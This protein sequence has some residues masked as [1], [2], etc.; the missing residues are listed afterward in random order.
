MSTHPDSA[1]P[2]VFLSYVREDSETVDRIQE[3]L[4]AAGVRVWRDTEDL[5]PGQDWRL[6]I[7]QAIQQNALVFI[8]C[9]SEDSARRTA[10]Y[11]NEELYLAVEQLRLRR[12]D[13]DWLIPVRLDEVPLPAFEIAPGRGLD[14]LQYVDLFGDRWD[15]GTA[16]LVTAV[17]RILASFHEQSTQRPSTP[18]SPDSTPALTTA[19]R[20]PARPIEIGTGPSEEVRVDYLN[21]GSFYSWRRDDDATLEFRSIVAT[22]SVGTDTLTTATRQQFRDLLT[23]TKWTDLLQSWEQKWS[24]GTPSTYWNLEGSNDQWTAT[25]VWTSPHSP[26]RARTTL[27]L[28]RPSPHSH[29]GIYVV[30]DQRVRILGSA[31]SDEP[32]IGEPVTLTDVYWV[33]DALLVTGC[34]LADSPLLPV[35]TQGSTWGMKYPA[36]SLT[37][38]RGDVSVGLT[39]LIQADQERFDDTQPLRNHVPFQS[40]VPVSTL[41]EQAS[42]HGLIVRWLTNML[43]NMHY[44]SPEGLTRGLPH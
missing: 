38:R 35:L 34:Q 2:H 22:T 25:A 9:F 26:S 32:E 42:R 13:Q 37:A 16:R 11:Q 20:A 29:D 30:M 19:T 4:E 10:S 6:R 14:S 23:S 5:W 3:I 7:R 39:E 18:I 44:R 21:P 31:N 12:P 28:P 40:H 8:A 24:P 41:H 27:G 36:V 15:A 17:L 33:L 1:Q 43:T